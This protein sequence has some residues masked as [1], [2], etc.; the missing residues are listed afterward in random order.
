[1]SDELFREVDEEVRQDRY[2][3]V[4]KRY[5]TLL[6]I[7]VV[8][9]VGATVAFV[10]WRGAQESAREADSTR[11]LAAVVQEQT[12]RDT[13]ILQLRDIANDGTP[14]YRFLASLGEASLLADAGNTAEAVAVFDS[15]AADDD[16]GASYRDMA[17]LLAVARGME[18]LGSD[19]VE[20]RLS[21]L[22]TEDNPF[23]V[24]AREF[25]AVSAIRNGNDVQ[26]RELL[27]ANVDDSE[28]PPAS[29]NRA[30]ELLSALGN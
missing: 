22:N 8:A 24:T 19:E 27:Q 21:A 14:G 23:R 6:V 10:V 15:I 17:R 16:L 9:I 7:A 12:Q 29:R 4:W 3:Q 1:M 25:L 2:Q 28:A 11:F 5:G 13:A 20:Q 18:L 26:A 30:I